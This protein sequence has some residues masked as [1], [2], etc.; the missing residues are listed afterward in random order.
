[1]NRLRDPTVKLQIAEEVRRLYLTEYAQIWE[2]F[3][4][5]IKM[6]QT[7]DLT[8]AVQMA[9]VLSAPDT[10]LLPLMRAMSHETTLGGAKDLAG[11][12]EAKARDVLQQSRK[13]LQDL[14]GGKPQGAAVAPG[15]RIESIVDDRFVNLRQMVTPAGGQGPAPIDATIALINEMHVQLNAAETATKGGNTPPPSDVP[16]KVKAEASRLPEPMRSLLETLRVS[17]T[18]AAL[19]AT[20]ATFGNEINAQIGDFCRQAIT[21]RYPFVRSAQRDVT[22]ADF[23]ELFG[24][25]GLFDSFF[26]QKLASF[27]DTSTKPWSFR[28]LGGASMGSPGTLLQFQQAATI[29]DTFFRGGGKVASLRLD[30]K[31]LEMDTSITQFILDVDGQLVKYAH[32]PQIPAQVQWPGPR[33]SAQVRVAL[34]PVSASGASGLV[35]DGPWALLKLFDRLQIDLG[36]APERFRA[37]FNVE[38]RKAVFEVT[39]SSVRNPFRLPELEQ[40]SCPGRL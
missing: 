33:G 7:G 39:T 4:A 8:Q 34:T 25:G 9:R 6:V 38:G 10:P 27:V 20:R 26:Q 14:F 16:N 18:A 5:D 15:S 29:R 1:Q 23:G 24:V 11:K 30:F 12:V 40:F 3:I 21:G 13:E 36:A 17:G 2:Q 19:E 32:G 28:Q 31:P 22:Q 35:T 37:T